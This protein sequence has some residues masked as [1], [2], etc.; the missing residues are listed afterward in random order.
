M[1]FRH[2][3]PKV[4]SYH[5][6][7]ELQYLVVF[8]KIFSICPYSLSYLF[9]SVLWFLDSLFGD[10]LTQNRFHVL[11]TSRGWS[12]VCRQ[13]EEGKPNTEDGSKGT[14]FPVRLTVAYLAGKCL[15]QIFFDV[16]SSTTLGK[17]SNHS[18]LLRTRSLY[19]GKLKTGTTSPVLS[20]SS[21]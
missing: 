19:D 12:I 1:G 6:V 9:P 2:S 17:L 13:Y 14:S 3:F 21:S 4:E 15:I 16:A 20:I 18:F 11:K 10:F 7:L 8:G 5:L